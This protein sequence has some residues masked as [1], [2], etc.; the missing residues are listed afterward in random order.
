[1]KLSTFARIQTG[2]YAKTNPHGE[3]VY[4]QSRH[5]DESGNLREKLDTELLVDSK[6]SKHLLAEGDVLFMAKGSRNL[7]SIF[8]GANIKAVPSSSYLVVRVLDQFKTQII[9]EYLQWFINHPRTQERL[10]SH[11][12]GS[13]IPSVTLADFAALEVP[14]PD[15]ETQTRILAIAKLATKERELLTLLGDLKSNDIDQKL[16]SKAK[17]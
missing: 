16:L 17:S 13:G 2:V 8:S 10:R 7:A 6:M 11:A 1:M 5:F 4:L 9:P 15:I 14:V 12:K 3:W